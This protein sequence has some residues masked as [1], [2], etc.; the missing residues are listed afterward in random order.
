FFLKAGDRGFLYPTE[1][2]ASKGAAIFFDRGVVVRVFAVIFLTTALGGVIFQSTTY[3]LPK[4]FE[5]RLQDIAASLTLVGVW[6]AFVFAMAAFAQLV[7]G[8]LEDKHSTRTIFALVTATKAVLFAIMINMF[9]APALIVLLAFMLVVIGQILIND[10]LVGR[11]AKR[12][13]RSRAYAA[14]SLDTF[15]VMSITLPSIA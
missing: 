10:V 5:L 1:A 9:G 3:V 15:S 6:S 4:F 7:A 8:H 12:G 13:W 14:R 2:A 11:V